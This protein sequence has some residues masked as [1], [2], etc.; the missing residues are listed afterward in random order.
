[1]LDMAALCELLAKKRLEPTARHEDPTHLQAALSLSER[2][3]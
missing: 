1:M 2:R 3:A